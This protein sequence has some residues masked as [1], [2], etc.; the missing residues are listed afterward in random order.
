MKRIAT[1]FLLVP[2]AVYAALFA[3]WWFSLRSSRLWRCSAF[4]EYAAITGSFAPVG[5]VAGILILVAPQSQFI[6]LIILAAL[7]A[8]C[9]PLAAPNLEKVSLARR[10]WFWELFTSSDRGKP[11]SC[12]MTAPTS[13][14]DSE[15]ARGTTG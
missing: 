1:A 14:R 15:P 8:M 4:R 6:L 5:Y 7:A 11:P 10:L 12:C 2:V 9:L 13:G 3:P